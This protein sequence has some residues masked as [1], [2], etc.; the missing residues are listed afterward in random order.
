MKILN[1]RVDSGESMEKI[2]KF[3][4]MTEDEFIAL[5]KNDDFIEGTVVRIPL[6]QK[7]VVTPCDS[8][9]DLA[10]KLLITQEELKQKFGD[11]FFIGELLEL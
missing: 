8:A 11:T 7:C 2:C 4:H 6:K 5:N 3:F 10:K 1:Y 9:H